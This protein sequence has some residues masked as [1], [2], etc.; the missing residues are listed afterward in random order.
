MC[1]GCLCL[2]YRNLCLLTSQP[3][4][5][6]AAAAAAAEEEEEVVVAYLPPPPWMCCARDVG[7]ECPASVETPT[8]RPPDNSTNPITGSDMVCAVGLFCA[9]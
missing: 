9:L 1:R 7:V 6:A 3:A 4:A 2:C 8:G 5:A